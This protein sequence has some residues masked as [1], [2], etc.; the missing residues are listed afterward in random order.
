MVLEVAV[1]LAVE[2]RVETGSEIAEK[3]QMINI[4]N[5]LEVAKACILNTSF[6]HKY[7]TYG[8]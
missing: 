2:E 3:E 8:K 4:S 1:I 5:I 7:E 6:R